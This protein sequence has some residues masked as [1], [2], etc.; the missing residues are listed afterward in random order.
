M[1]STYLTNA[2]RGYFADHGDHAIDTAGTDGAAVGLFLALYRCAADGGTSKGAISRKEDIH[3]HA[4][5][6]LVDWTETHI[7]E[8]DRTADA[9]HIAS[10]GSRQIDVKS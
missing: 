3:G 2:S 1:A 4:R 10:I 7:S 8:A 6:R 5:I 9:A